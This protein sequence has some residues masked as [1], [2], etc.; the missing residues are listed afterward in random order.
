MGES[1]GVYTVFVGTLEGKKPLGKPR[2]RWED[3][4]KMDLKEVGSGLG[5]PRIEPDGGRV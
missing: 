4:A 2:R 3:N 1:E 5:W